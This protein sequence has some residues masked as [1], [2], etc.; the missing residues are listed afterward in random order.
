[1]ISRLLEVCFIVSEVLPNYIKKPSRTPFLASPL[2]E[3]V[4]L[5]PGCSE[6]VLIWKASQNK[7]SC[8]RPSLTDMSKP[9]KLCPVLD[10]LFPIPNKMVAKLGLVRSQFED[11]HVIHNV[12]TM[13]QYWLV[14]ILGKV[15]RCS[16]QICYVL[17]MH[18][19]KQPQ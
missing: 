10:K 6:S 14:Y 7:L 15:E 17:H 8:F 3:C 12:K 16:C 4:Y 19:N 18:E 11:K 13:L 5:V 2:F 9:A 1:M